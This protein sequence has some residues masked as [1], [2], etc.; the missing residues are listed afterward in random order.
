MNVLQ[1]QE[2]KI[3]KTGRSSSKDSVDSPKSSKSSQ[4]AV[5]PLSASTFDGVDPLSM[6]VAAAAVA[7]K[8]DPLSAA[9]DPGIS[10]KDSVSL[11]FWIF[12]YYHQLTIKEI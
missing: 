6:F 1:V 5:D 7:P 3:K 9:V 10:R 8:V 12:F 11:P 4:Q 2:A